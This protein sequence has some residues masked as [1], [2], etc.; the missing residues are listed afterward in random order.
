M[1][2][3]KPYWRDVPE[4][5]RLAIEA[6]MGSAI[7]RA[8]RVFG[9]YGPSATFRICLED[10]RTLF[11][12]GAGKGSNEVN[13]RVLP[14]EERAYRELGSIRP[15]APAFFGSVA[16]PGWHLLLLEDLSRTTK[17]PPWTEELALGATSPRSTCAACANG[18]RWRTWTPTA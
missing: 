2:E 15:V 16:A 10:G 18:A 12:K 7:A 9:G 4:A 1:R 13:W 17:V 14:N 11:A 5:V 3:P 8:H 6:A